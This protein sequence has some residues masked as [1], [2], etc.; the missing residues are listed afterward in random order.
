MAVAVLI[1]ITYA[2][3][4]DYLFS[5]V[6]KTYLRGENSAT[7]DD[8]TLFPS[9]VIV[10]DNAKPWRKDSA[11]NVKK[12]PEKLRENLEKTNTA[13]LIVIKNGKIL[14]EEYWDDHNYKS[15]TNSFSMAKAVTVLLLGAAIDDKK[16]ESENQNFSDFYPDFS[17]NNFG[18]LL[19]LRDLA[20]MQSGLEWDENYKNPLSPN[21]KAYY[22]NSLSDAVFNRNLKEK[23]G[24]NFEYQSGNTQ[25]LGFAIRKAVQLPLASYASKKLWIPL[26]ME[27]NANWTTDEV[28][29]EKTFCCIHSNSRDF[30]KLGLLLLNKGKVDSAQIISEK[31]IEK[32]ITPTKQSHNIYGLGIWTDYDAKY[33]HYFYRGILGQYIIV[34]P[35]KNLVIVRTGSDNNIELSKR[36][37]PSQVEFIVNEV[38]ENL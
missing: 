30:A 8:G 37:L 35:E 1:A 6:A 33:P 23:P 20:A 19:T 21:A 24:Q 11:Y 15:R 7:I 28:G 31:F 36:G 14:H 26:G 32:M 5:G 3:G 29:M 10:A 18:S 17:P 9:H 16:I 34:V 13:S 25:L 27:Q 2:T 38:V 22:G 4:Y 12:I